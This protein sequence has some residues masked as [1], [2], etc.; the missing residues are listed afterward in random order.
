MVITIECKLV[1]IKEKFLEEVKKGLPDK[2]VN[3][4]LDDIHLEAIIEGEEE[5]KPLKNLFIIA[6]IK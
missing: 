5:K 6:D 2:Q 4:T 3:T 1:E